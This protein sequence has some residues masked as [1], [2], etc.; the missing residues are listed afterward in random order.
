VPTGA[1]GILPFSIADYCRGVVVVVLLP[2]LDDVEPVLELP[3]PVVEG[4][5]TPV[6]VRTPTPVPMLTP[7]DGRRIVVVVR[8]SP[9]TTTAAGRRL[10]TIT[11]RLAGVATTRVRF[12]FLA[13]FVFFLIT[14]TLE[15]RSS[16]ATMWRV[17]DRVTV[18]SAPL[19]S[20]TTAPVLPVPMVVRTFTP[21]V[22]VV[23]PC[24][25]VVVA[26]GVAVVVV[27]CEGWF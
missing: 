7:V 8:V 26:C 6:P 1:P 17:R 11:V 20:R 24:E 19:R 16:V 21:G 9:P 25:V 4:V 10:C 23:A 14:V 18:T 27:V 22:V 13:T 2:G 3:E 12:F 15:G 5:D